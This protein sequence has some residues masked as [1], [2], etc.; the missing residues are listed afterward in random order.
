MSKGVLV[1]ANGW[2]VSYYLIQIRPNY[3]YHNYKGL[4]TLNTTSYQMAMPHQY[5]PIC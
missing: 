1:L 5:N 4:T 3:I 2:P